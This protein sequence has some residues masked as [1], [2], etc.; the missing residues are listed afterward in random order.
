MPRQFKDAMEKAGLTKR[1]TCY[2][3][4][5][6]FATHLLESGIDIRTIQAKRGQE[7]TIDRSR[8]GFLN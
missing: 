2:T 7:K 6:T 5:H 1:V 3:L 8:M 4:R